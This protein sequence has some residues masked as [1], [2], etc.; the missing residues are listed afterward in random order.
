MHRLEEVLGTEKFADAV[1]CVVVDQDGAEQ[2]LLGLDIVRLD[3]EGA[4]IV[5]RHG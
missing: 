2:R 4:G 5:G 1:E 3:A